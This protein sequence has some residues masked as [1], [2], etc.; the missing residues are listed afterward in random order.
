MSEIDHVAFGINTPFWTEFMLP[1]IQSRCKSVLRTL[2]TSKTNDEDI[3][4]GWFQA[5][6]WVVNLPMAELAE[7]KKEEDTRERDSRVANLD[8]FRA[9]H[10]FRSP[11]PTPNPG[12]LT[13]TSEES[14]A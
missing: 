8:E 3:Q 12:E 6:E 13:D 2:A 11:Y 5:L 14:N 9:E 4:R 7:A 10:G 1:K